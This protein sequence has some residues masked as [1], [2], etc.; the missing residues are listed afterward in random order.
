MRT[1][2]VREWTLVLNK[3]SKIPG[4]N[5]GIFIAYKIGNVGM[6]VWTAKR[7]NK[8]YIIQKA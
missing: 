1:K 7:E 3:H 4:G 8:P 5:I 2:V 6:Y